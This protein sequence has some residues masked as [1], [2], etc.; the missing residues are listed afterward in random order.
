MRCRKG[1]KFSI[2][3]ALL[4]KVELEKARF[5]PS[6]EASGADRIVPDLHSSE[7]APSKRT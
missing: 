3:Q 5:L 2:T 6:G 4:L 7:M 1:Q